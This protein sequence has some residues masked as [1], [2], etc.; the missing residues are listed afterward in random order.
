MEGESNT[1]AA[2]GLSN[3]AGWIVGGALGGALGAIAFGIVMV[4]FEPGVVSSAI[5]A[6]Y[7]LQPVDPI[8]WSIHVAHGIALGVVFGLIVTRKP[9]LGALRRDVETDVISRTG[10][11]VRTIAAGFIFGLTVWAILPLLVLP[12]WVDTV[13]TGGSQTFPATTATS[14]LGHLLFG[15]VLGAV[16]AA[17]VDLRAYTS[18]TVLSE[19]R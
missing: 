13:S 17:T 11:I 9:I 19:R 5:P 3:S 1:A 7:G 14:L 16:F 6:I 8:G 10:I 15:T 4:L 18:D 2:F 12:V